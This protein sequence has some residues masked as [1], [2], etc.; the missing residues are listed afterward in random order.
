MTVVGLHREPGDNAAKKTAG[1]KGTL[2]F[3]GCEKVPEGAFVY[4][5]AGCDMIRGEVGNSIVELPRAGV[6]RWSV[7]WHDCTAEVISRRISFTS[8]KE[9]TD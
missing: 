7:G 8:E 5:D 4:R 1:N 3:G 2:D 6:V 9:V